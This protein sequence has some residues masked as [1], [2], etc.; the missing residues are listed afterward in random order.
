MA[1][2]LSEKNRLLLVRLLLVTAALILLF[3]LFLISP[4]RDIV[5]KAQSEQDIVL[6]DDSGALPDEREA[7]NDY[8]D[9]NLDGSE[10][11]A[12]GSD[13]DD[14]ESDDGAAGGEAGGGAEAPTV[15]RPPVIEEF[16]I[17]PIDVMEA[18]R[19][20]EAIPITFVEQPFW[21]TVSASDPEGEVI[22]FEIDVSHGLIHDIARFDDNTIQFIWFSPP[23]SEGLIETT[24]NATVEVTAVDFSGGRDRAVINLAMIPESS[25]GGGESADP[26]GAFSVAQTY[27]AT[28]IAARS[29]Y[30]NSAGD[31][32]TGTIIVGD[33]NSNR[34]Y[35]GY[36][37]FSLEGIAR[38]AVEDITGA[39]IK[40]NII[41]K[42]GNPQS[43]GRF[44][45]FKA[46]NYG[47]ALDS[48][49][50]AVGG[51]RFMMLG[52]ESFNSGSTAQGSLVTEVRRALSAG[53]TNLQVKIGLDA[54]TNNNNV[55]D[56]YQFNPGNVELV[57]DYTE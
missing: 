56:M 51:T 23:N 20:G 16:I 24:V 9:E 42:S 15:N 46:F 27:R 50:F 26:G 13:G 47:P 19:S 7:G 38:V 52:T 25:G 48:S 34:Q 28:A 39:H 32:R 37:T 36:L 1:I 55:W 57:I 53:Q 49:D 44:V 6:E 21:F 41:N 43:V 8:A 17:G 33:D 10:E 14:A 18:V 30:V 3:L 54:T 29:G 2:E 11:S 5:F 45:D 22:D 40:F 12:A 4:L 35:K 31:V